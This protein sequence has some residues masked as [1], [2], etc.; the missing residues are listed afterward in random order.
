MASTATD[1]IAA[2]AGIVALLLTAGLFWFNQ[3]Q[4][5]ADERRK[6]AALVSSWAHR[7]EPGDVQ[8]RV[9]VSNQS[10][11]PVYE[12]EAYLPPRNFAPGEPGT[13][14][15][16]VLPPKATIER[17]VTRADPS[18]PGP[19]YIPRLQLS[20]IDRNGRRWLRDRDGK[21]TTLDD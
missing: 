4:Q 5:R 19:R 8:R 15:V 14:R 9:S 6:Q 20:F 18:H 21:L 16:T 11:E 13:F 12:L 10:D 17:L 7:V 3:F 2:V 1:W